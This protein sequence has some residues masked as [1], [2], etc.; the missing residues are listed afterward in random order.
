M[1][2]GRRPGGEWGQGESSGSVT[3]GLLAVIL[4]V[5]GTPVLVVAGAITWVIF[6]Y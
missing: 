1:G 4:V 3:N 6:Q 2:L 5:L